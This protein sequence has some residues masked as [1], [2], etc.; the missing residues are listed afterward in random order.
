MELVR[1]SGWVLKSLSTEQQDD[2]NIVLAAVSHF[3]WALEFASKDKQNNDNIVTAAINQD[4]NAYQFASIEQKNKK[5]NDVLKISPFALK[6]INEETFNTFSE[7]DI[8]QLIEKE[9]HSLKYM[10]ELIKDN[11]IFV[12]TCLRNDGTTLKHASERLRRSYLHAET[13]V[14]EDGNALAYVL[15]FGDNLIKLSKIAVNQKIGALR[16]A[17]QNAFTNDQLKTFLDND[18]NSYYYLSL[19]NQEYFLSYVNSKIKQPM[20][21]LMDLQK[22]ADRN[23]LL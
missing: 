14:R 8:L 23:I 13:A 5:I 9:P 15:I 20:T 4:W 1:N 7:P 11:E 2:Y 12:M 6:Y 3:G 18:L 17:D 16:Y 10:S 21:P 19:K 22:I